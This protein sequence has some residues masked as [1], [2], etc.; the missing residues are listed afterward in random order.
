MLLRLL[1][2][3]TPQGSRSFAW[4]SGDVDRNPEVV[5]IGLKTSP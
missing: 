5:L 1:G 3:K 2:T 4:R